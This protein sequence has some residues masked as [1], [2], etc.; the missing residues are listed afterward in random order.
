MPPIADHRGEDKA[1][2]KQSRRHSILIVDDEL[3]IIERLSE[4][5]QRIGYRV[6]VANN[7][8]EAFNQ[9]SKKPID[10][11]VTDIRMHNGDGIELINRIH[12]IDPVIPIIVVTGDKNEELEAVDLRSRRN[13][14]IL[15]KP[16][17]LKE[18]TETMK[19]NLEKH[20]G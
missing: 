16:L 3:S 13:V 15:R 6:T 1:T 14:T 4:I 17:D 12:K 9:Y 7:G 5:F 8:N 10:L 11:V 20:L 2:E 18:L 19:H